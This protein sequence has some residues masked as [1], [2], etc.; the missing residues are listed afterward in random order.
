LGVRIRQRRIRRVSGLRPE[1]GDETLGGPNPNFALA[2]RIRQR[3]FWSA[4]PHNRNVKI[5]VEKG[6]ATLAGT[7]DTWL[8]R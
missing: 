1:R 2:E 4:S 8:D 7:V 6:R 3:C 5:G